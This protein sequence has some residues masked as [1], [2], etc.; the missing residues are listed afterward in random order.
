M[1]RATCDGGT[2]QITLGISIHALREE[3]DLSE[4][5]DLVPKLTISIHAL[6][7]ESDAMCGKQYIEIPDFNPRSP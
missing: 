2:V 3:S 4:F 7:E 5:K 1:R 6:R